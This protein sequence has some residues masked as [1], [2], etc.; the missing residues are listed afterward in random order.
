MSKII[1]LLGGLV[2]IA[3]LGFGATRIPVHPQD[4]NTKDIKE[5]TGEP[6][7]IIEGKLTE[8]QRKHS[9]IYKGYKQ[10]QWRR[11][12][13]NRLIDTTDDVEII[14]EVGELP[15]LSSLNLQRVLQRLT[16]AADIIVTGDI[17][18]KSS[19]INEDGTFVFTDYELSIEEIYKNN[20]SAIQQGGNIT[21]TRT[22]GA[23][24]LN[25][26]TVRAL[27]FRSEPLQVNKQYILYLKY[28]PET[29]S[30]S[31]IYEDM[32]DD[33][34]QLNKDT[35]VQVSRK[36]YPIGEDD[37]T[38]VAAFMNAVRDALNKTCN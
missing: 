33:T 19:H 34:F 27:D 2:F 26:R 37:E 16:C 13:T 1:W 28:L 9:R 14:E 4:K 20:A 36:P 29:D 12:I 8:K 35:V 23:V 31:P 11:K 15:R 7:S 38:P 21:I 3:L 18:N 30:Y 17:Q 5:K 24:K 22:G 32:Y 10:S 25:G 6:T